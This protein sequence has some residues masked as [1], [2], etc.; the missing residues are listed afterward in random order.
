[1]TLGGAVVAGGV[2]VTGLCGCYV[3]II[4]SEPSTLSCTSC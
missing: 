3:R 1:M 2:V 4:L